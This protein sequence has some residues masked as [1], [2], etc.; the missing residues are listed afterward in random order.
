LQKSDIEATARP[1]IF[2]MSF[3]P[4]PN[5]VSDSS[6]QRSVANPFTE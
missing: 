1:K 3:I 6:N 2:V 5:V 4:T